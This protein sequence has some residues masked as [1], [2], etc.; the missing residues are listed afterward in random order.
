MT[1]ARPVSKTWLLFLKKFP[2]RKVEIAPWNLPTIFRAPIRPVIGMF[3]K[4]RPILQKVTVGMFL[5]PT[6][7]QGKF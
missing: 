6:K 4:Q 3:A 5:E 7:L 1:L 2:K